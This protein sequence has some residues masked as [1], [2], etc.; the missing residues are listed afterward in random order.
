MK[1]IIQISLFVLFV[2][3]VSGLMGFIYIEQ[4]KQPVKKVVININHHGEKGF[5]SEK[6][7]SNVIKDFDSIPHQKVKA[8]KT[9][10][11]ESEI[12][13]NPF[14]EMVDAFINI[15][16]ELIINVEEKQAFVRIYNQNHTGFYVDYDGNILPL[17]NDFTPRV[18]IANGYINIT[19]D[20]KKINI[21]DS[22]YAKTKLVDLF[23]LTK[24]I[25]E[26]QFLKAQISEIYVNSRGEFDLIPQL[27]NHLIRFGTME[28]AKIKLNNL[29]IFYKKALIGEGWNKYE[30]INLKYKNQVVCKRK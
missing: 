6:A 30:T 28:D 12:S 14:V 29:D 3:A 18:L 17:S 20:I 7:I 15:D 1:R 2:L 8:V 19:P 11:I 25:S 10:A 23:E 24:L 21:F 4:G 9:S 16:K 22:V 13:N 5:L 27:G 26:N